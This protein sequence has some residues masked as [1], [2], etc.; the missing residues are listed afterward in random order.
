MFHHLN[1][2]CFYR[3]HPVSSALITSYLDLG[4]TSRFKSQT[5]LKHQLITDISLS[6]LPNA[7]QHRINCKKQIKERCK[8]LL[9]RTKSERKRYNDTI[10]N[11][12]I[13]LVMIHDRSTLSNR[14]K[15]KS[16]FGHVA[17][18]HPVT[19]SI[20][21]V[22]TSYWPLLLILSRHSQASRFHMPHCCSL[23][24]LHDNY[25]RP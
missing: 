11:H 6:Q 3:I 1:S 24:L 19:P 14:M 10:Q 17:S 2:P 23:Q 20:I 4:L 18:G 12:T 16:R 8:T 5:L 21:S 22:I 25:L 13:P 7:M 15:S 9:R